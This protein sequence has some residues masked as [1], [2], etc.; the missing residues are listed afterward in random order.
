[1]QFGKRDFK[2]YLCN[3]YETRHFVLS[4]FNCGAVGLRKSPFV[5][6]FSEI[7]AFQDLRFKSFLST[8]EIISCHLML[9]FHNL[10]TLEVINF[11]KEFQ[12]NSS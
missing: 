7:L 1:M 3:L 8:H 2:L 4:L 6:V 5:E 11:W 12:I 9:T 10:P